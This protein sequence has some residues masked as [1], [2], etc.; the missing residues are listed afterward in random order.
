MQ[1]QIAGAYQAP[2]L[3]TPRHAE[4]AADLH[5]LGRLREA[6]LLDGDAGKVAALDAEMAPLYAAFDALAQ[7][8]E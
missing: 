5:R 4:L 8:E 6:A 7:P 3:P 1:N 2:P